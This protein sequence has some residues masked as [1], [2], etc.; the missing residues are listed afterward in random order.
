MGKITKSHPFQ[1]ILHKCQMT[2]MC[3]DKQYATFNVNKIHISRNYIL[4]SFKNTQTIHISEKITSQKNPKTNKKT[5]FSRNYFP[6]W[7]TKWEGNSSLWPC[8]LCVQYGWSCGM[9]TGFSQSGFLIVSPQY[10]PIRSS[11][12][13]KFS[14]RYSQWRDCYL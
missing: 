12:G 3:F 6:I 9:P 7:S 5:T 2:S 11:D 1:C 10:D 4:F 13:C 8:M 14:M